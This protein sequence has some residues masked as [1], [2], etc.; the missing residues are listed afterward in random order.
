MKLS[1]RDFLKKTQCDRSKPALQSECPLASQSTLNPTANEWNLATSNE[2]ASQPQERSRDDSVNMYTAMASAVRASFMMPKPEILTFNGDPVMYYKFIRCFETNIQDQI[3][4][5]SLRLSY[6]IQ[7]CT[8][9]AKESIEDSMIQEPTEGYQR[10]RKILEK[11][12]DRPHIIAHAY[13]QKLTEGPVLKPN[14]YK[15]LS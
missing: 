1:L 13:I 14:D 5:S 6:L 3:S 15:A 11:R 10:A 12:Y 4:D 2:P 8:G 7:C 9:E